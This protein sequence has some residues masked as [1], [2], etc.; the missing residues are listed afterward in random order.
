MAKLTHTNRKV[1]SGQP[2]ARPSL[3]GK[4][5]S[6]PNK[7]AE[8]IQEKVWQHIS[9]FPAET[10][11]YTRTQNL[12]RLYV[13]AFLTINKMYDEYKMHCD[14]VNEKPVSSQMYGH[15]FNND[16]NL[17]FV[18]PRSDTCV[19]CDHADSGSELH[20]SKAEAAFNMQRLDRAST[21]N[22]TTLYHV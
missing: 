17:G 22:G 20:K 9:S 1:S 7:T 8:D 19:V 21:S 13:S 10:S 5:T 6:W 15:I 2:T 11:H 14:S 12:Y 3:R 4:H 18:S 16:F